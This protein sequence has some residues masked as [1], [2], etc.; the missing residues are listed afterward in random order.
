VGGTHGGARPAA[1]RLPAG[2]GAQGNRG[3]GGR[4]QWQHGQQQL[5]RKHVHIWGKQHGYGY[6]QAVCWHVTDAIAA[7]L[8][9]LP[10]TKYCC[11][12][13]C[14]ALL[15]IER[16]LEEFVESQIKMENEKK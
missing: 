4:W 2:R 3:Q 5:R 10:L 6:W 7:M 12:C 15:Q 11:C 9:M 13:C 8:P 1:G 16:R 14:L